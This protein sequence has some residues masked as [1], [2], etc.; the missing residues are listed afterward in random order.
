MVF[1]ISYA[2]VQWYK[3][4]VTYL[5][6]STYL[7]TRSSVKNKADFENPFFTRQW[8]LFNDRLLFDFG[9]NMFAANW[10]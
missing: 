10:R 4:D 1:F 8:P 5:I 6:S 7:W 9:K 3:D 2:M